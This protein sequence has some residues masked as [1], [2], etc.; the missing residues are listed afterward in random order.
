MIVNKFKLPNKN[1]L[2]WLGYQPIYGCENILILAGVEVLFLKTIKSFNIVDIQR[3]MEKLSH[4][5]FFKKYEWPDNSSGYDLYRE[6]KET[7]EY[8]RD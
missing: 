4:E 5:E 8:P 6:L 2:I 3:D 1:T 7:E